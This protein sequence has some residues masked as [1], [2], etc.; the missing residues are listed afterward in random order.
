[1]CWC[2]LTA[3]S[4]T[5]S[6]QDV[7]S[8]LSRR[9]DELSNNLTT[10]VSACILRV[11]HCAILCTLCAIRRHFFHFLLEHLSIASLGIPPPPPP[12]RDHGDLTASYCPGGEFDREIDSG[13]GHIDRRQSAP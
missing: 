6:L 9:V 3:L 4:Q 1:M 2:S 5:K 8:S 13:V 10:L 7:I 12:P 11:I